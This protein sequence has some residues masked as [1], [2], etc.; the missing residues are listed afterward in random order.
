MGGNL[1]RELN[2][3]FKVNL[4][5]QNLRFMQ[6]ANRILHVVIRRTWSAP[7]QSIPVVEGLEPR[8]L[9]SAEFGMGMDAP[10]DPLINDPHDSLNDLN[11]L[12]SLAQ[13][14]Q[15]DPGTSINPLDNS[16]IS[17]LDALLSTEDHVLEQQIVFVD[18][19]VED[20]ELFIADIKAQYNNVA[21]EIVLLDSEQNG[22]EQINNAL[23]GYS[24]ISAI[25]I[26]SHGS[27]NGIQL[28][29]TWLNASNVNDYAQTIAGWS[30]IFSSDGD[31]LLYGCNLAGSA[32]GQELVNTLAQLTNAD[33]A[34][35]DDL[36]GD[37]A[38]GGDWELEYSIGKIESELALSNAFQQNWS[39]VLG[40]ITVTTAADVL[41]GDADTSS[42]AALSLNPGADGRISLREAIIASNTDI[43]MDTIILGA[44]N[45]AIGTI[46]LD[47]T[48]GDF[49]IRDDLTITGVSPATTFVDGG[50]LT[51]VFHIHDDA[52]ISVTISDLTI[53]NGLTAL[54]I[55]GDG[56]G[57]LI[58]GSANTPTVTLNN[59][60]LS[61]NE[62]TGLSDQGGAIYN[63]GNLIINR[64]L[65]VNNES[66]A[67]GGIYNS[68]TGTVSLE[69]VT[70]SDNTASGLLGLGDGGGI[71]NAGNATLRNVTI[72]EN[73]AFSQGGGIFVAGGVLDIANSIVADNNTDLNGN[74][75]SSGNNIFGDD[76]NASGFD[77]SDF[78]NVDPLLGSLSDNG[79]DSQTYAPTAVEVID[80]ANPALA[81]LVD[82][83]GF[84]RDDGSPDIGAFEVG[85]STSA[86]SQL[87]ATNVTQTQS[88]IEDAV[89]VAITDIVVSDVDVGEIVSATLTLA[90][91]LAGSLT[92]SGDASYT[93]STGVWTIT[94]TVAIV[95][96]AL[97]NVAFVPASNYDQNTT[98]S[99]NIEDGG[100]NGV[101]PVT[102]TIT[103]NVTAVNDQLSA[104][105]VTQTQSYTEDAASVAITDIV[106]SD[107]DT[108]EIVTATLTLADPLAGSLTITG[109]ASYTAGTGVWTITDTV[110]NVNT[111]LANVAFVPASNYD[112]DTTISV[113]IVDGGEDGVVPVTGTITLNVTP[114]GDTP[115]VQN[116]STDINTQSGLISVN[117]NA[118]DG[119]EVTHF[120]ISG[121]TNGTLTLA[122]GI[123]AVV[124]NQY[125]TVAEGIAGLRFTPDMD[126][127]A[128]GAFSVES[129]ENGV[130][131]A[132]QSNAATSAITVG[133]TVTP[134]TIPSPIIDDPEEDPLDNVDDPINNQPDPD[135][136]TETDPG[137]DSNPELPGDNPSDDGLDDSVSLNTAD[138]PTLNS[139]DTLFRIS[140]IIDDD[141]TREQ[142]ASI[143]E[144]L[145]EIF[146]SSLA[147]GESFVAAELGNDGSE[148]ENLFVNEDFIAELDQVRE[149][150]ND[151]AILSQTLIGS[152]V[153]ISSGISVGYVIWI[154]RGGL[155]LASLLS[156]LPA[157]RL[158]DPLPVLAR[159]EDINDSDN[160]GDSL[161]SIVEQQNNQSR[162]NNSSD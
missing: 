57:I 12:E 101:V 103:L 40:T 59:V 104:T 47:D 58:D 88:Y 39:G 9:L 129:S 135:D 149:D 4:S 5:L 76:S 45:Y 85:A 140:Q 48:Q 111:A 130:T 96:A 145:L 106:V 138:Q 119:M 83:R 153:I 6:S 156:S 116:T 93:D 16:F 148:S 107:V 134:P 64:A 132:L 94:D 3:Y 141:S 62:T 43:G 49:D 126:S 125:I 155:L 102:G 66:D 14:Q 50:D 18:E 22:I 152:T 2:K 42:L 110:A 60:V 98:I 84:L 52:N 35:S 109:S 70:L 136:T 67:G 161:A 147:S 117:R 162:A 63:S 34:A 15:Y 61:D 11:S 123:T 82:Q 65:I 68:A 115:Q 159:F 146:S 157:W 28:G 142:P 137:D 72:A 86:N 71:Y 90:D 26:I 31:L 78:R 133:S 27:E 91:P 127:T 80:N 55:N 131:V 113:N 29:N 114:V 154:A 74:L 21:F 33:V 89:S 46:G 158:V 121:I 144:Q 20:Y 112:Q 128:S 150:I 143:G 77:V 160:E 100:E 75:S 124:N 105:N 32:A 87:T 36:T 17:D 1:T 37:D 139:V 151:I 51:R 24:D 41:D 97:A 7:S 95:N 54:F 81:P 30:E 120:R 118:N 25:H 13:L 8:I 79:G 56:G 23:D 92:I 38:L 10:R 108:G 19:S 53:R 99:V 73:T 122:D 44:D 69:N